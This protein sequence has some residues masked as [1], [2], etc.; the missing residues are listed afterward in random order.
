M[1]SLVESNQAEGKDGISDIENHA[2][3]S[4]LRKIDRVL[5][6]TVDE[7]FDSDEFAA[8]N[9]GIEVEGSV[10]RSKLNSLS[11]VTKIMPS[12]SGVTDKS[13][14]RPKGFQVQ[15]DSSKKR[16]RFVQQS[17]VGP[18]PSPQRGGDSCPSNNTSSSGGLYILRNDAY[19]K[20]LWKSVFH[21]PPSSPIRDAS[22]RKDV[23]NSL[24]SRIVR[25]RIDSSTPLEKEDYSISSRVDSAYF[26]TSSV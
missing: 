25:G 14:N 16:V 12:H 22:N 8:R 9:V 6:T 20:D 5:S 15:T 21:S 23:A 13:T 11:P 1:S 19:F 10:H 2:K 18:A 4:P 24:P 26:S 17:K 7:S 3:S